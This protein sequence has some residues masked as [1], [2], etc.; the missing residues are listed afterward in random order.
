MGNKNIIVTKASGMPD[1]FAEEKLRKSLLKSGA[2]DEVIDSIVAT[3]K[4]KLYDGITTK[5]IY[6]LAFTLLKKS[7]ASHA[8]RYNLKRA[9]M[10]LGP[11]GFPFE[12]YVAAIFGWQGYN[13]QTQLFLA[14]A[15]VTH[16]VD[17]LAQNNQHALLIECKY[18]NGQGV[19]SDVKVPLYIHSRYLDVLKEWDKTPEKKRLDGAVVTNTK[20]S[21]DAVKYGTCAGLY[22]LG[23]DY[24]GDK[25]LR[26]LID[27]SGLY[28]VTCLNTLT[29]KEKEFILQAGVVLSKD[30]V[31]YEALLRKAGIAQ[32]R[33]S[34][35]LAEAEELCNK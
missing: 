2:K 8:G 7:G 22:L 11:S 32:I 29:N 3:V 35:V 14:G 9:I 20:F 26:S 24:P 27:K 4:S 25:S 18:H 6:R 17:V 31:K 23:W 30:I 13:V 33:I 12:K 28:P 1:K 10:A 16:E 34:K 5:K 19:I 21:S 15:C